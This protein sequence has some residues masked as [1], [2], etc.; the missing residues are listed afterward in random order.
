MAFSNCFLTAD[1]FVKSIFSR[2]AVSP[3]H[4]DRRFLW[5]FWSPNTSLSFPVR[6]CYRE[7]VTTWIYSF[8]LFVDTGITPWTTN[9]N[10]LNSP[11]TGFRVSMGCWRPQMSWHTAEFH[12][13]FLIFCFAM[14][15]HETWFEFMRLPVLTVHA[16]EEKNADVF[17]NWNWRDC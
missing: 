16:L 12:V 10:L 2:K 4:I 14:Q 15:F 6:N 8:A 11:P 1:L 5:S 7:S 3:V 13:Y 9:R 17:T